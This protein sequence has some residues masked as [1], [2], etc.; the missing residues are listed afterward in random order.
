[1]TISQIRCLWCLQLFNRPHGSG[2][3]PQYCSISHRQRAQ[4][5]R[6]EE[7]RIDAAVAAAIATLQQDSE[8]SA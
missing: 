3:P 8:E 4:E 7:R 6:A 2:P 1:M 5:K